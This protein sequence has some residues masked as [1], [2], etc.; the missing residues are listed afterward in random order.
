MHGVRLVRAPFAG[1]ALAIAPPVLAQQAPAEDTV[2]VTP[3]PAEGEV[4]PP[5]VPPEHVEPPVPQEPEPP[6]PA[7]QPTTPGE[8]TVP[9][10]AAP[11]GAAAPEADENG[12]AGWYPGFAIKSRDGKFKLRLGLQAAY[13]FEPYWRDGESQDRKTFFVLR[14]IL[15]GHVF[16]KWI[17]FWTSFEFAANPP[18]LLDSYIELQPKKEFGARIGQQFTPYS[19]HEYLG[20][21]EILF[22]E[23]SPVAEYFWTGRDKGVTLLGSLGDGVLDYWAGAY[24]GT[25]LRQFTAID[26]NY[27]LEARVTLSPM[28]RVATN[29]APYITAERPVPFRCS[30][31]LQG[32]Y[33]NVETA[34][35]N[36]NSSTF[37]FDVEGSGQRRKQ[38]AGGADVWLQ[39]GPFA[40]LVEGNVRRTDPN[41]PNNAYTSLGVWGQVG[42]MV[43]DRTLDVG[44]R[45]NLLNAS[46][47]LSHDLFYSIEGQVGYYP[48]HTQNLVLKLRYGY[49]K[50]ENP[51]V[52]NAPLFTKTGNHNLITAQL[53]LAI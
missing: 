10:A 53:G 52:E 11:A 13:R 45:G 38:A 2:Q 34:A 26:G 16:E 5:V 3:P 18:F 42:L 36:F 7:A 40:A 44:V 17:K 32:Y 41:G 37:R 48:V 8:E 47:E 21:Q 46:N 49:A 22:P 20:P 30:F 29:E 33:G 6:P 27:V 19:R 15:E 4:P 51:G 39:G 1:L 12:V 25:P 23:W 28:G 31:T 24:S 43:V 50:Q 9:A 14:P 35:E